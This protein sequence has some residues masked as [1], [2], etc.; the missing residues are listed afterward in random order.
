MQ[1]Q[2]ATHPRSSS[3]SSVP[4]LP[5]LESNLAIHPRHAVTVHS[6]EIPLLAARLSAKRDAD[7]FGLP[8]TVYRTADTHGWAYT[9]PIA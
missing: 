1:V 4:G 8:M 5:D 6:C 9:N 3:E 7:K 2:Q